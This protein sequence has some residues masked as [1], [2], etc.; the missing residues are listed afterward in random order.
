MRMACDATA[1]PRS[2]VVWAVHRFVTAPPCIIITDVAD[3]A[4]PQLALTVE[5]AICVTVVEERGGDRRE[6]RVGPLGEGDARLLGALLLGRVD[7]PPADDGPWRGA[8]AGGSRTVRLE[9]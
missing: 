2:V 5:D 3:S 8:I 1:K 9:R 7:L 6:L 4:D